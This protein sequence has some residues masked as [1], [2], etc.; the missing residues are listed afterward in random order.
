MGWLTYPLAG[1]HLP[2]TERLSSSRAALKGLCISLVPV[3]TLYSSIR[4]HSPTSVLSTAIFHPCSLGKGYKLKQARHQDCLI[5]VWKRPS[6]VPKKRLTRPLA[7]QQSPPLKWL[8]TLRLLTPANITGTVISNCEGDA[9]LLP[10]EPKLFNLICFII[11]QLIS[12]R[13]PRPCFARV[14]CFLVAIVLC[15]CRGDK[16]RR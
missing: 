7:F 3:A 12:T 16:I 4:G 5:C 15:W 14:A 10:S 1:C 8:R 9:W 13:A 2:R 6:L 11:Q